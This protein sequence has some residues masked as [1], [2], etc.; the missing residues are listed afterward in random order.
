MHTSIKQ[1]K[2]L[3][4]TKIDQPI[5]ISNVDDLNR[6]DTGFYGKYVCETLKKVRKAII[7]STKIECQLLSCHHRRCE[8]GTCPQCEQEL[9]HIE[10]LIINKTIGVN[11]IENNNNY[12]MS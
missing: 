11:K 10:E 8:S 3:G 9:R 12:E 6:T 7:A 1:L 4:F 5:Y 2:E